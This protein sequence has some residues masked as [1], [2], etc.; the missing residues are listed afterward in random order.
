MNS[1]NSF[2]KIDI[3]KLLLRLEDDIKKIVDNVEKLSQEN[4]L[5]IWNLNKSL[6]LKEAT[7]D[8]SEI[9]D[10]I[11]SQDENVKA[12]ESSVVKIKAYLDLQDDQS[13]IELSKDL[14]IL[15]ENIKSLKDSENR[16]KELQRV[17]KELEDAKSFISENTLK[18][19]RLKKAVE[20]LQKLKSNDGESVLV[21]YFNDNL[22]EIRR[23][24]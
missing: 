12:L 21:G 23:Y 7:N 4:D 17:T 11:K 3:D 22:K 5:L 18:H 15:E 8:I 10:G 24:I 20:I 9:L 1:D 14:Y 2:E 6:Q 16:Q 19:S 13:L